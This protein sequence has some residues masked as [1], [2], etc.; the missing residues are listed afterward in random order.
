MTFWNADCWVAILVYKDVCSG[1]IEAT[2]LHVD[3]ESLLFLLVV[4]HLAVRE[5]NF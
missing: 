1:D 5:V 3:D 2:H 4:R